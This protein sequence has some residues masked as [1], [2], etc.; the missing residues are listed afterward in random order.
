MIADAD[1]S[2]L[3]IEATEMMTYGLS[4]SVTIDADDYSDAYVCMK[5]AC[6]E[7]AWALY[8]DDRQADPE[9]KGI[10]ELTVETINIVFNNSDRVGQFSTS[11]I[12][13]LRDYLTSVPGSL[14]IPVVRA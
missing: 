13:L 7:Q 4:W 1:K 12:N 3:L 2:R 8:S 5:H 14:N 6:C 9:T 10:S 11:A